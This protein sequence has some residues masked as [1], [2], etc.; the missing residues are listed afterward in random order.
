VHLVRD[1]LPEARDP[2][3]VRIICV[4]NSWRGDDAAGLA[5]ARRLRATP[6]ERAEIVEQE[7][8]PTALI[9]SLERVDTAWIVDAVSSGAEPG[10]VHRLDAV[11]QQLPSGPF[12]ASTHHLGIAD[13]VELA[14]A[15][16]KLPRHLIVYGIEGKSFDAGNDLT[17]AV[18]AAV[19]RVVESLRAEVAELA[20]EA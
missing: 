13:A 2:T 7:G 17:P 10:T 8:E 9:Y 15:L 12:G 1:A 14:R 20:S 4:G 3:V 11:E 6:D 16:D 5:V 19:E 18:A